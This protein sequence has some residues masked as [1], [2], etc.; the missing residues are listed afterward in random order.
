MALPEILFFSAFLLLLSFWVDLCHQAAGKED[1]DEDMEASFHENLLQNKSMKSN[2]LT[3]GSR[4]KCCSLRC[5]SKVQSRQKIVILVTVMM[6]ILMIMCALLIWMG[7]TYNYLDSSMVTRVYADFYSVISFLLGG[8]I[9]CY[10][11]VL[12]MKMRKV[13]SER[14]FSEMRKVA[15]LAIVSVGCFTS[16]ALVAIFTDTII[17]YNLELQLNSV[18]TSLFLIIYY[19]LGSSIPSSFV[20]WVMRELPASPVANKYDDE[21]RTSTFVNVSPVVRTQPQQWTTST[22]LQNQISRASPI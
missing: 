22:S 20:L 7:D 10:G 5:L 9:A 18:A 1:E 12:Y 8:T 3:P 19:F 14:A 17:L 2:P 15:G 16:S 6:V 21:S 11:L 4:R 13:R